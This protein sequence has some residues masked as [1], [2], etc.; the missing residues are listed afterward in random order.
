MEFGN[1]D[2]TENDAAEDQETDFN[3]PD[4]AFKAIEQG[5]EQNILDLMKQSDDETM[6]TMDDGMAFKPFRL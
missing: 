1:F 2:L 3:D 6:K 4:A 5:E